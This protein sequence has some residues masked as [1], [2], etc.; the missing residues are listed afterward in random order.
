M[1]DFIELSA[2]E[3]NIPTSGK[4]CILFH[5]PG[6]CAGCKRVIESLKKRPCEGW[7]I[8]LVNAENEELRPLVDE[9]SVAM[10]PTLIIYKDGK[11]INRMSGL[12]G[13]LASADEDFGEVS[14]Q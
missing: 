11:M 13:F 9:Y 2:P 14:V 4:C 6:H 5:L 7:T 3:L 12:K 8:I 1:V 10:A